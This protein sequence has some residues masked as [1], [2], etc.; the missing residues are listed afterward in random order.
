MINGK[1][2]IGSFGSYRKCIRS[3][4][5]VCS[6]IYRQTEKIKTRSTLYYDTNRQS[7]AR[8]IHTIYR[9]YIR[10]LC[11]NRTIYEQLTRYVHLH[12][13]TYGDNKSIQ[14]YCVSLKVRLIA[15]ECTRCVV[16]DSQHFGDRARE[17]LVRVD[18]HR[19]IQ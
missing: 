17:I 7:V 19:Y 4:K 12:E 14:I 9:M 2:D 5:K 15:C 18:M 10:K 16:I 6:T 1:N 8:V 13:L 3:K 11:T